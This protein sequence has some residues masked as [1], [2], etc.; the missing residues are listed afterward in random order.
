MTEISM[1]ASIWALLLILQT[2]N[3][4][5]GITSSANH[6]GD[7]SSK[8]AC[9]AAAAAAEQTGSLSYTQTAYICVP[10]K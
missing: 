8:A 6:I 9:T 10:K 1:T 5:G 7:F 3:A 2:T 4:S